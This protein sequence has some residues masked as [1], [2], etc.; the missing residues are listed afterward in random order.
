MKLEAFPANRMRQ[1]DQK[2]F[3]EISAWGLKT[4]T[5]GHCWGQLQVS[6]EA[7][8]CT[9]RQECANQGAC[10]LSKFPF[11]DQHSLCAQTVIQNLTLTLIR[12]PTPTPSVT[13]TLGQDRV[14]VVKT[15]SNGH[16][17]CCCY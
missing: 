13:L 8:V 14:A 16:N 6:Q 12:N 7:T 10:T 2:W 17:Q 11:G 4:N 1:A 3:R 9:K 15:T 5:G